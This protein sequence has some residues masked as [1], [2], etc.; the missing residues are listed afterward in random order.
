[1]SDTATENV[2]EVKELKVTSVEQLKGYAGGELV[3]LPPFAENQ[4]FVARLKRPSLFKMIKCG[5]I[6]NSLVTQANKLFTGG[7]AAVKAQ[8]LDENMMDNLFTIL[9]AVCEDSLVEPT[10]QQILDASLDLTDQQ[11]MFVFNYSQN[12]V[13]ALESFR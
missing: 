6:P 4:P 1:M 2:L 12:G 7:T 13:A 11:K 8:A 10:Y 5:K 3:A 9:D